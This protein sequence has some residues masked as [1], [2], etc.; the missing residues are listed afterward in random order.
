MEE[1]Q[2]PAVLVG[3]DELPQAFFEGIARFFFFSFS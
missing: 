2:Q 3:F 1:E